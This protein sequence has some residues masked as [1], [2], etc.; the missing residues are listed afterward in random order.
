VLLQVPPQQQQ[1][2]V[3][4]QIAPQLKR[5]LLEALQRRTIMA[6]MPTPLEAV[7]LQYMT[8]QQQADYLQQLSA[9]QP[10]PP[11]PGAAAQ[12][13]RGWFRALPALAHHTARTRSPL[14]S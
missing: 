5:T 1:P 3:P 11:R 7:Q 10:R 4:S 12:V 13:R 8:P 9:S 2:L 6:G 14:H